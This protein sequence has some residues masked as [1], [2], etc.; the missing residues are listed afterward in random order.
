MSDSLP[1]GL[2]KPRACGIKGSL[3]LGEAEAHDAFPP[4]AGVENTDI[5]N[6]GHAVIDREPACEFDVGRGRDSAE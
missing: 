2:R 1:G 5:G 4:A 6:R 3:M